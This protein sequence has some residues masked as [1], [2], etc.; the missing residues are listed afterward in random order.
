MRIRSLAEQA[1]AGLEKMIVFNELEAQRLY[2]EKQLAMRLGLGRTPVREALQR[3]SHD[4]MVEVHARR[5]I[6]VAPL[7]V[8]DQ[9][10]VLEVRRAIEGA[11][12]QHAAMRATEEQKI[13]MLVL[14]K[15]IM[16]A[17]MLDDDAE[18]LNCLREIHDCLV[19]ATQNLFFAQAMSPLLS[20][21][22]RFWFMNK[23]AA[24][25]RRGALLYHRV[26]CSVSRG[27][28]EMAKKASRDLMDYLKFFAESRQDSER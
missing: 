8:K 16:E 21:S 4:R 7:T 19:T 12:V 25:S 10:R 6:Q 17:A 11:C 5:G 26:L 14:G 28:C 20:R 23:G 18:V 27:D 9:L 22:R 15:G 24:D 3:L 2:T 13:Q 1:R